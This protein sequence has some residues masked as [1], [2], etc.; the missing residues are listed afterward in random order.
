MQQESYNYKGEHHVRVNK[1]KARKMYNQGKQVYLIQDMM[2]LDN[3]WQSPCPI[4]NKNGRD[5]D[6]IVNEFRFYNCD[7]E[8]GQGVK[9][10]VKQS[11]L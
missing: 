8:R 9:Y 2:R 5:F 4:D 11:D 7:S 3:A 6:G 1:T 10:F